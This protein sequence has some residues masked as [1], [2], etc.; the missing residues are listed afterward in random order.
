MCTFGDTRFLGCQHLPYPSNSS[1]TP[2]MHLSRHTWKLSVR[3]TL[4]ANPVR[5]LL[6]VL[7]RF[8]CAKPGLCR[9]RPS[10]R[11]FLSSELRSGTMNSVPS[12]MEYRTAVRC[13]SQVCALLK[14][15]AA[16]FAA[17]GRVT[18]DAVARRSFCQGSISNVSPPP[19]SCSRNRKLLFRKGAMLCVGPQDFC[20]EGQAAETLLSIVWCC[21]DLPWRNIMQVAPTCLVLV[22]RSACRCAGLEASSSKHPQHAR[23]IAEQCLA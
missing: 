1:G 12:P 5:C 18:R 8:G 19:G 10:T 23:P 9:R 4:I 14:W 7:G 16:K 20:K 6:H 11:K 17:P 15:L 3:P 22:P 2:G 13:P 21:N